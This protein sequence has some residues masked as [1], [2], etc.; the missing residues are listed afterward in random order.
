MKAVYVYTF[1]NYTTWR[2]KLGADSEFVIGVF[3]DSNV[4]TP[5]L[6]V[7]KK[8]RIRKRTIRVEHFDSL[9]DDLRTA[10][11]LLISDRTLPSER[12]KII[13]KLKNKSTQLVGESKGFLAAGGHCEFRVE[14]QSVKFQLSVPAARASGL[15]FS[16][17]LLRLSSAPA[18]STQEVGV[19]IQP[20]F[21]Q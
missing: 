18:K 13:A 8:R 14:G 17:K 15:S 21:S 4:L 6:E 5:L 3:G 10:R 12:D 16:A 19:E 2:S 1:G 9:D 7:A 11:I 20:Q